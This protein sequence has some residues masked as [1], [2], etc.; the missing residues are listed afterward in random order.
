MLDF[1]TFPRVAAGWIAG[2][3]DLAQWIQVSSPEPKVWHYV[4]TQGRDDADE[5]VSEFMVSYTIDGVTW[6]DADN[7]KSYPGNYNRGD[8]V[9]TYFNSPPTARALRI[10]PTKWVGEIAMRF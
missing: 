4:I 10:R 1:P 5:W 3:S 2:V 7:G 8:K 6:D 9:Y